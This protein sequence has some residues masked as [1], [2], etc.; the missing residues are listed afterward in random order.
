MTTRT[1]RFLQCPHC[2]L[3]IPIT[4]KAGG[5]VVKVSKPVAPKPVASPVQK[6]AAPTLESILGGSRENE[7]PTWLGY[8]AL[9]KLFGAAKNT[10]PKASAV[11]FMEALKEPGVTIESIY[12]HAELMTKSRRDPTYYTGMQKWFEEGCYQVPFDAADGNFLTGGC[13]GT[14]RLHARRRAE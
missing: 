12:R 4:G 9:H 2:G 7:T 14:D 11:L 1:D 6:L 8:W 13:D 3:D 10:R 5:T